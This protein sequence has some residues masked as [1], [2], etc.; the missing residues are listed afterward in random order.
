MNEYDGIDLH[1]DRMYDDCHAAINVKLYLG[2]LL[3][4]P[5]HLE[6]FGARAWDSVREMFW[7][8]ATDL[9]HERGYSNV[10]A[11][12]RSGGWLVPFYQRG[13]NPNEIVKRNLRTHAV[14]RVPL[15][16]QWPGQGP[17]L[18]Y[19]RYPDMDDIGERSRFRAFQREIVAMLDGVPAQ[20]RDEAQYYYDDA[21][22]RVV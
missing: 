13:M 18:G 3:V 5:E 16:M 15:M 6:C 1:S 8:R 20:I 14:T 4:L 7:E 22:E 17:T 9:A 19:P 10:F 21:L 11:E 12:G 2:R